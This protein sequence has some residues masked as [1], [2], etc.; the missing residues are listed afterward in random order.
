MSTAGLW[1]SYTRRSERD[2]TPDRNRKL[3]RLM[4]EGMKRGEKVRKNLIE[5][6]QR[7][8]KR[9]QLN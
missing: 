2:S 9:E 3:R 1:K 7:K 8:L 5:S 4:G 6:K